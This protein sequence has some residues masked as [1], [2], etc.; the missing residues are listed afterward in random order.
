MICKMAL[1]GDENIKD[2]KGGILIKEKNRKLLT[3]QE[4]W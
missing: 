4:A 2:V 3:E 1:D